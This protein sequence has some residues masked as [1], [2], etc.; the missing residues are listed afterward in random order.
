MLLHAALAKIIL[1]AFLIVCSSHAAVAEA[2]SR[3]H[4]AVWQVLDVK[5]RYPIPSEQW[6]TVLAA[7]DVIYLGEEH[8]NQ[9]HI[10]AALQVLRALFDKG[11]RPVLG[12]EMFGWDGQAALNQYGTNAE[13]ARDQFLKDAHWDENWGGT[14]ADY[15]PLIS[16]ARTRRVPVLALNPPRRLVRKVAVQGWK[17][18]IDDPEMMTWGMK[19]EPTV[20]DAAYR[21]VILRQLQLCHGGLPQDAYER[22]YEASMFRDEGMAKT[23]DD[24][25]HSASH[26]SSSIAGP[27]VSY[28]GG[29]HIQYQLP[30]PK[31][32]L[33]KHQGAVRQKSVYMTSFEPDHPEQVQEL[34][35]N[36]IADYVWLTP[37]GAHGPAKR[38]R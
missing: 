21:E 7:Q 2:P 15:E 24:S 19:D 23:I 17:N 29:G 20:E 25:L 30:I 31:R 28:T 27:I 38:C 9:W 5:S 36:A 13:L 26:D 3:E 37:I 11:R 8:R 32:V 35:D 34:L 33:R 6:L 18:A 16:F 10:E 14:F 1:L 12:M 22:M 4:F